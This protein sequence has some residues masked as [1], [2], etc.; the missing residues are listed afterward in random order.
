MAKSRRRRLWQSGLAGVCGFRAA[1]HSILLSYS[2]RVS[3]SLELLQASNDL[4]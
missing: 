2:V 1:H 3:D 4:S